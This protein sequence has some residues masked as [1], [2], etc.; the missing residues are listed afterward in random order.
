MKKKIIA[1]FLAFAMVL[2]LAA[3]GEKA[4]KTAENKDEKSAET[5]TYKAEAKGYNAS[6][7]IEVE[8]SLEGKKLKDIK[9]LKH[10]ET[11]GLGATALE[12]MPAKMVEANTVDIDNMSGATKTSDAL[13]AAVTDALNQAGI[14][15]EDLEG[16]SEKKEET[17][18]QAKTMDTD[19][20]VVG[21]GG[22]G[23]SAAIE[24]A[25]N[26]SKVVV[27]E[28]ASMTGGNTVKATGGM[29]AS[30]TEVQDE[31]K[32]DEA[33][34]NTIREKIEKAK[35][36][37][38]EIK[39]LAETVEKQL[40]E[41]KK[42]PKG[43][44]DSSELFQLD[45]IIG[46]GGKNNKDLVKT[47]T[48]NSD[49]GIAWLKE[50]GMDLSTTGFLGGA[51]VERAH[52]PE[53]DGKT[54]SVG[55]YLVPK[56]TEVAEKKGIEIVYDTDVK[57]ILMK[58]DQA[59]GVKADNITVNSK[60][61]IIATG[62]F[63]ANLEMVE[64]YK[65][66]L[67]GFVTTN[68]PTVTGDGIKM[69]SDIGAATVDME[70][71][72]IHPTVEQGS[73]SLI[74]ESVRGDGAILVNQ[75]GKRFIDEVNTRDVVSEAEIRQTGGYAYLIFDQNMVDKS[76][77]LKGYIEKGFTTQ[78]DTIEELGKALEIDGAVIKETLET[79]NKAVDAKKDEE[80]NRTAFTEKLDKAP[81]YSIKLSPGIHH[82][83]G[84]LVINQD[85]QVL[86]EDGSP[87][88]NLYAA[89]E[90]TG[91]V[92]GANRLGGNAVADIVVFGRIAGTKAAE[93]SK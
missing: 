17:D 46:G 92:H 36:E 70:Q 49:E 75:E 83:M 60:S 64:K 86:K 67:K 56:L 54:L 3:C 6:K 58:D 55:S 38:P 10:E 14:K 73:S 47:L 15:P 50:N 87:I 71:I 26:G 30:E 84:G 34:E 89:G 12:K 21:A 1:L 53:K 51:S 37:F 48:D 18:D 42:D 9:I 43:Y 57:E 45:T 72:Q 24:A 82:T 52:K 68:A 40:D 62:G 19:I 23:L 69:A 20:V 80:F 63:G 79:W 32:F 66:E 81:F 33:A 11:D 65:P 31:D 39:D 22:A 91:G 88:K 76:E 28:K 59:V 29:N 61:V 35:K 2:S 27:L 25:N 74:T 44:F 4:D 78:A 90:V 93:N 7:P 77:P 5:S 85:A 16:G 8:V 13:K 41:F